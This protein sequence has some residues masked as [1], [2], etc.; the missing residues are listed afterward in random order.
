MRLAA[1]P[2]TVNI[3]GKSLTFRPTLYAALRLERYGFEKLLQDIA[4]GSLTAI[5][6]VAMETCAE[7]FDLGSALETDLVPLGLNLAL[8]SEATSAVIA[9]MLDLGG[10]KDQPEQPAKD[11]PQ[12]LSD[13]YQ[14]L[15]GIATG[16]LGWSADQAW[17]ATPAE[18]AVAAKARYKF[19]AR[20]FGAAENKEGY[21]PRNTKR[22]LDATAKLKSLARVM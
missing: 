16:V 5:N 20:L 9:E 7:E 15:F 10:G 19:A 21:D 1:D 2:I 22:D 3:G 14:E 18:I 6:T 4:E 8:L 12:T 13:L 11:A 17:N